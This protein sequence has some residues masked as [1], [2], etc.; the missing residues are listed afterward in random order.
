MNLNLYRFMVF[1]TF[2]VAIASVACKKQNSTL[3]PAQLIG[4]NL[5]E[6]EAIL[7]KPGFIEKQKGKYPSETRYYKIDK[8]NLSRIG[9][10]VQAGDKKVGVVSYQFP[11]STVKSWQEALKIIGID[12]S[13]AKS[14]GTQYFVLPDRKEGETNFE[15]TKTKVVLELEGKWE[16]VIWS[17]T[18]QQKK[19]PKY[20]HLLFSWSPLA[21]EPAAPPPPGF[22]NR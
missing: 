18:W 15:G 19:D 20:H 11:K 3:A 9:L 6:C 17:P 22:N 4:K 10:Q 16:D 13:Q 2:L 7:G 12:A 8:E 5:D 21:P 14:R 1:L